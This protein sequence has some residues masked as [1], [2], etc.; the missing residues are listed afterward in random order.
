VNEFEGALRMYL[1]DY[2]T[3]EEVQHVCRDLGFRDWT[4]L[5][6]TAVL[7]EEAEVLQQESVSS[8]NDSGQ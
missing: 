7:P 5:L 8:G 4:Q 3:I 1:P 6:D 2:V